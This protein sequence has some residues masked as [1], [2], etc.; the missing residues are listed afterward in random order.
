MSQV[1]IVQFA[2]AEAILYHGDP[3]AA[4]ELRDDFDCAP[5][6]VIPAGECVVDCAWE[7]NGWLRV[8]YRRVG[9]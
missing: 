5:R 8:T 4:W 2:C 7:K 9:E 6:E 1:S 3:A